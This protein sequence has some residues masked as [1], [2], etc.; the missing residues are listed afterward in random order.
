M[1]RSSHQAFCQNICM[2]YN[3]DSIDIAAT[4]YLP[5]TLVVKP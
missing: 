2:I 5:F 4:L 3:T 1:P